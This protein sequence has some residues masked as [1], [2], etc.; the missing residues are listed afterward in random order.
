MPQKFG[1]SFLLTANDQ[2]FRKVFGNNKRFLTDSEN[3]YQRYAWRIRK[4]RDKVISYASGFGLAGV[5]YASA[6][7][8]SSI[9]RTAA[10][11]EASMKKVQAVSGATSSEIEKLTN[12]TKRLG[13]T[14][15]FTA[16]EASEGL[17]FLAQTGFTA[18]ES[19]KALPGL[20]NLAA[21]GGIELGE[22][23][24]IATNVL[25]GFG[26]EA[27]A[28]GKVVDSLAETATSS[29]TNILQLGQALS[30]VAPIAKNVGL[31]VDETAAIIGKLGD[32]GIQATRAGTGLRAVISALLSPAG[33]A[34]SVLE[35]LGVTTLNSAGEMRP[36]L[37]IFADLSA[38]GASAKD[39]VDIF[40]RIASNTATVLLSEGAPAL[41]EFAK[42][43]GAPALR[44]FAK[45]IGNA[46][47][48]STKMAETIQEGL[49]G[50]FTELKSALEGL[51]LVLSENLSFLE[52]IVDTAA[53]L[54]RG[55]TATLGLRQEPCR[56]EARFRRSLTRTGLFRS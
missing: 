44:E 5:A 4:I 46:E 50:A 32:A 12:L 26:L 40:G 20:L 16:V 35:R 7:A 39:V 8:L 15:K 6:R 30:Y 43:I 24:D 49:G 1:L 48:A 55:Y 45:Q 38:A 27:E 53:K 21:A 18:N 22:A 47:G 41:R 31:S 25:K 14:T 36:L 51:R 52:S 23:A 2:K 37:D 17:F 19:L 9:V 42:Q 29:N 11:F 3:A 54:T 10:E 33:E 34:K 13:S 56:H 28:T